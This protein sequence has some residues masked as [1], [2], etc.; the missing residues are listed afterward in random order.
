MPKLTKALWVSD[1]FDER[2]E[3]ILELQA[4]WLNFML[5][6]IS[7]QHECCAT[8]QQGRGVERLNFAL[9]SDGMIHYS[10]FEFAG[11]NLK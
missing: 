3:L 4:M 2:A 9:D 1:S 5:R 7:A 10:S 11:V 8:E 6:S